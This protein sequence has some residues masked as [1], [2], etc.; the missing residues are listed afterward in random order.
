[1][2]DV[3]GRAAKEAARRDTGTH[4][5]VMLEERAESICEAARVPMLF[6]RRSSDC[7]VLLWA[8]HRAMCGASS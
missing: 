8:R 2:S 6:Q 1:M 4:H 7:R 3:V 5:M